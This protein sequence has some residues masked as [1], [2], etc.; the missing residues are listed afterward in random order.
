MT[1]LNLTNTAEAHA[2]GLSPIPEY[3]GGKLSA[4]YATGHGISMGDPE[5]GGNLQ[6]VS[7]TA[8]EEFLAYLQELEGAGYT[9]AFYRELGENKY[10]QYVKGSELVYTYYTDC[11]KEVHVIC[12]L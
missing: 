6:V 9:K 2:W 8:A 10:A 11:E 1:E 4:V 5:K 7:E 3:K 12:D